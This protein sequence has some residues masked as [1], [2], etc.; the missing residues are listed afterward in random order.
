M[1]G[2]VEDVLLAGGKFVS[3]HL[4]RYGLSEQRD[5]EPQVGRCVEEEF[6]DRDLQDLS[7]L[8]KR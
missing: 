6:D 4:H 5:E 8:V 3:I 2:A 1:E 7:G